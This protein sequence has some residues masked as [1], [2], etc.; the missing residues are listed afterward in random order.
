MRAL[1]LSFGRRFLAIGVGA[2]LASAAWMAAAL[3]NP[4]P[5][6]QVTVTALERSARGPEAAPLLRLTGV[7]PPTL[8]DGLTWPGAPPLPEAFQALFEGQVRIDRAG[9]YTFWLEAA[10]EAELILDDRVVAKT[11][12]QTPGPALG[13]ADLTPG[14]RA[15]TLRYVRRAD[16]NRRPGVSLAWARDAVSARPIAPESVTRPQVPSWRFRMLDPL[17]AAALLAAIWTAAAIARAALGPVRFRRL[18]FRLAAAAGGAALILTGAEIALRLGSIRPREYLPANLWQRLK[19][20]P[21]TTVRYSGW[22]PLNVK[23]FEVDVAFNSRGW[24]DREHPLEKPAGVRR[25]AIVGDSY[26]AGQETE[27]AQTFPKLLERELN[28]RAEGRRAEVLSFGRGGTG[29]T[30]QLEF[31]PTD[32]LPHAPDLVVLAFFPGNDVLENSPTLKE[33]SRRWVEEIFLRKMVAGKAALLDG[34]IWIERSYL[35]RV[36]VDRLIDLYLARLDWFDPEVKRGDL[37][38]PEWRL[39]QRGEPEA[40][41]E[42]AWATTLEAIGRMQALCR[43]HGADFA[44]MLIHSVQVP[45]FSGDPPENNP[46]WDFRSPN[47]R[48]A[49]YC[50][51]RGIPFLD[52]EPAFAGHARRGGPPLRWK[53]DGHW[54]AAGH[55]LAARELLGFVEPIL[56]RRAEVEMG[57]ASGRRGDAPQGA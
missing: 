22:L 38:A 54:N 57:N 55:A 17:R 12:P 48:I 26:V 19:F 36:L 47:R 31:L 46:T 42:A 39:Y 29:T 37:I 27:L 5:G 49:R 32:V 1:R 14:P 10:G 35:N 33:T 13:Y 15:L 45:G 44:L 6:L 21:G 4:P 53:Y 52:L 8:G 25:V 11:D 3:I 24:R 30:D 7:A 41:W 43:A 34:G 16:P 20:E 40:V 18:A 56:A 51:E 23:E 50:A 28:A 9:A 2:A